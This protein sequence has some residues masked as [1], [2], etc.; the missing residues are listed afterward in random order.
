VLGVIVIE[1]FLHAI[2]ISRGWTALAWGLGICSSA[3]G[4]GAQLDR[5]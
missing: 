5:P 4:A 2:A 1:Y 3:A